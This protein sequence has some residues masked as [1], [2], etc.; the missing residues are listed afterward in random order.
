MNVLK[1]AEAAVVAAE[2]EIKRL[3]SQAVVSNEWA[4]V[5]RLASWAQALRAIL[6]ADERMLP[7]PETAPR[8]DEAVR[9]SL[10]SS[11][12]Q[13]KAPIRK[14]AATPLK[15]G[16]LNEKATGRQRKVDR[17]EYPSFVR[18]GDSLIKIGWSKKDRS[19]YEHRAPRN[20]L[21]KI[22]AAIAKL[23]TSKSRFS[24]E[25]LLSLVNSSS[26]RD[27][28][29]TYQTYLCIAWLRQRGLLEQ[30]G[31][32]GYSCGISSGLKQVVD[33]NWG[34]IPLQQ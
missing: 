18:D 15:R 26:A 17:R 7:E 19:E 14:S 30:H 4:A 9:S 11:A 34:E 13:V 1:Q 28:I 33:E 29:P 8:I 22:V 21:E 24:V 27:E 20:A 25:E 5:A 10:E 23:A 6:E 16:S 12:E 31:R 32:Q 2:T 3:A